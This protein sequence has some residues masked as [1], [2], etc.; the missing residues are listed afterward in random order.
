LARIGTVLLVVALLAGT[1][2]AFA[3]TQA[4]KSERWPVIS[5]RLD[6]VFAP[7]C[8][9]PTA[10]A[11]LSVRLRKADRI[12]AEI[13]AENGD[14]VR[15]LA[16]NRRYPRGEAAFVWDGRTDAGDLA[17]EG[18]Y[19]LRLHLQRQDRTILVPVAVRLDDT[20]PGVVLERVRSQEFSPDGDGVGER[21]RVVYRSDEPGRAVLSVRGP[22][23]PETVVGRGR[24]KPAGKA[25]IGW[26]GTVQGRL[27]APGGYTLLLRVSDAA[28]NLS[29][30]IE[31]PVRLAPGS[32]G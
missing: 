9:C 13:V 16:E 23:V 11:N 1:T 15:T 19:R 3:V 17:P 25:S 20:A 7:T 18:L 12:T 31:V 24:T 14:T 30:P 22:G 4:L 32:A 27:L 8:D 2:A 10:A 6:R 5:P 28:G 26:N 29:D 21:V